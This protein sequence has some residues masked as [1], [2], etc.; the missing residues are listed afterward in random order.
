MTTKG[1]YWQRRACERE[2]QKCAARDIAY[3]RDVRKPGAAERQRQHQ[4]QAHANVVR[5]VF[6]SETTRRRQ[7][8]E[9]PAHGRG[10]ITY[11]KQIADLQRQLEVEQAQIAAQHNAGEAAQSAAEAAR[12]AAE[13][14]HAAKQ[15]QNIARPFRAQYP[16]SRMLQHHVS[17]CRREDKDVHA[18]SAAQ[19]SCLHLGRENA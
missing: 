12:I 1:S 16:Q 18:G 2:R 7:S 19:Q 4:I 11:Q 8:L 13:A 3:P 5:K 10:A 15:T 14:A 6:W 17:T 9:S